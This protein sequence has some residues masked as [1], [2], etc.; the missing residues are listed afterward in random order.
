MGSVCTSIKTPKEVKIESDRKNQHESGLTFKASSTNLSKPNSRQL[1]E[2]GK[3]QKKP[4]HKAAV[5]ERLVEDNAMEASA[6]EIMDKPKTEEDVKM[7]MAALNNHFILRSLDEDSRNMIVEDMKFYIIGPKEII[8]EQGQPGVCFFVVASGRLEVIV[9]G[10]RKNLL[11]PGNGFGELALLDNR[12]RT[13]TVKTYDKCT[14]WGVDRFAFKEAVKKVNVMNHEENKVFIDS[15]P[16]FQAL[17][18]QQKDSLLSVLTTQRWT[19]G[20]KIVKEG[21][22]GNLFYIIK[23]GIVTCTQNDIEIRQ[24]QK[25]DFFGEQAL[26]YNTPRTATVTAIGDVKVVSISSDSLIDVLGNSLEQILYKNT[27][28]IACEKSQNLKALS[29]DQREKVLEKVE[30]VKYQPGE[31]IVPRGGKIGEKIWIILKGRVRGPQGSIEVFSCIGDE[32]LDKSIPDEYLVDYIAELETDVSEITKE[33]LEECIGGNFLQVTI[34]N[35]ALAVLKKVHLLRGLT[36][37]KFVS[38]MRALKVVHFSD[39]DTIVLQSNPGDSFY[40]IKTGKVNVFKNDAKIRTITKHDY[41]GERSVLFNDFRTATVFADGPVSCWLLEKEDFLNII[42]E[43]IRK[44]LVRRID[45]QD[46][47]I[48]L[49]D[50]IPIKT[51]GKGMFGNVILVAN[52]TNRNMYALKTVT[53]E[54][55]DVFGLYENLRLERTISLQLDHTMIA[56]LIKTY[57]DP[58]RVYFLMEYVMGND[59]FDVLRDMQLVKDADAKYYA[60]SIVVMLEHLHERDIIYRDLKPENIMIDEEGYPKL[61]DF[62]TAKI[63]HGRTYTTVGTPHYMAPEI[64]LGSGYNFAAD[65]WSLGIM[66]YEFLYGGVPFGEDEDDTQKVYQKILEHKITW[67]GQADPTSQA[68]P[69]IFQ[70]LNKNP[71]ARTGGSIENLKNHKWFANFNWDRLLSRQLKMPYLPKLKSLHDEIEAAFSNSNELELFLQIE[72]DQDV[73]PNIRLRERNQIQN[74]DEDF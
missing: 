54:K 25:G 4:R 34:H 71:A 3:N 10:A 5:D 64:I 14:L 42:D 18:P 41:F 62:G 15:V 73:L 74:W 20:Q 55:I 70:L 53:R 8:F 45:L 63:V 32:G 39:G 65:W 72:E 16:L 1:K 37:D 57:K 67:Q 69:L 68:K 59:L 29:I 33:K 7:I 21:D 44:Q 2:E 31:V 35:E 61:I 27:Q 11:G 49:K 6:A 26:L 52:K 51:I 30:V 23:E 48:A 38:L 56:K 28:R 50:L 19:S 17:T 43:E 36:Q 12:P 40:I 9:N 58:K 46:D 13:A 66:I 60:A 22:V 24:M 47:S